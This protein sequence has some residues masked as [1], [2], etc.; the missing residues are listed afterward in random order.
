MNND[1]KVK[2][3]LTK[4]K[5]DMLTNAKLGNLSGGERR[6]VSIA[7]ALVGKP[8]LPILDEP[9]GSLD[10]LSRHQ[11]WDALLTLKGKVTMVLATQIVEEAELFCDFISIIKDGRLE[12]NGSPSQIKDKL[13]YDYNFEITINQGLFFDKLD[14]ERDIDQKIS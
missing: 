10:Q 14:I 11:V 4:L 7:L 1:N 8:S 6:V 5:L 9:T 3:I 13:S 2:E 12:I